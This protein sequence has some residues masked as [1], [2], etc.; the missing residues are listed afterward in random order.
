M[1][2]FRRKMG[3]FVISEIWFSEEIYDV[4]G[5]DAVQF[6]N[7]TFTGDMPGF[8]KEVAQTLVQD[9]N[10]SIEDIWNSM[11]KRETRLHITKALE[12]PTIVIRFNEKYA[13]FEEINKEFRK[14][15]GLPPMMITPSEME[16]NNY[17]LSTYEKNETV[18]GGHLCVKDDKRIRQLISGSNINAETGVSRT[19][20]GRANKLAIWNMIKHFKEAGLQEFDFGG[21]ATV[22]VT[23]ELA[24]INRFKAGFG[25]TLC[26]KY[27]YSK[28]YSKAYNASKSLFLT[29]LTAGN[30]LKKFGKK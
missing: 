2:E 24:G 16:K 28:S 4:E 12:D 8:K 9:L 27:S 29:A 3:P 17:F 10:K 26:D 15:K 19:I 14:V 1:I 22:D 20:Y 11:D 5:V 13:E 6:K 21:Y 25:G 30:K 18:L 23:E 7:S